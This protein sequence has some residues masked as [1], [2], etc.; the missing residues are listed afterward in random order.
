MHDE[1]LPLVLGL[2]PPLTASSPI[3]TSLSPSV[4]SLLSP[5]IPINN[6]LF[7]LSN[8]I[9]PTY[10]NSHCIFLKAISFVI[11]SKTLPFY[12]ASISAASTS[13]QGAGIGAFIALACNIYNDDILPIMKLV[14]ALAEQ[15]SVDHDAHVVNTIASLTTALGA[16]NSRVSLDSLSSEVVDPN[17]GGL[18]TILCTVCTVLQNQLHTFLT[19]QVI[20]D[21]FN[22]FFITQDA[23]R[24]T[25]NGS[26]TNGSDAASS[27]PNPYHLDWSK[28][29]DLIGGYAADVY[30]LGVHLQILHTCK[31]AED[32]LPYDLPPPPPNPSSTTSNPLLPYL[33]TALPHLKTLASERL[34]SQLL[35][36][37]INASLNDL[38]ETYFLTPHLDTLTNLDL[39]ASLAAYP[40]L[41]HVP[42]DFEYPSNFDSTATAPPNPPARLDRDEINLPL[43]LID[44]NPDSV[45]YSIYGKSKTPTPTLVTVRTQ[46][47]LVCDERLKISLDIELTKGAAVNLTIGNVT[48]IFEHGDTGVITVTTLPSSATTDLPVSTTRFKA[49]LNFTP[50]LNTLLLTP[51]AEHPP[52]ELLLPALDAGTPTPLTLA[53]D[54]VKLEGGVV[55]DQMDPKAVLNDLAVSYR[56]RGRGAMCEH[57]EDHFVNPPLNPLFSPGLAKGDQVHAL[58]PQ[59]PGLQ[60]ARRHLHPQL[61]RPLL[62]RVLQNCFPASRQRGRH[63]IYHHAEFGRVRQNSDAAE[64]DSGGGRAGEGDLE[65]EGQDAQREL[66]GTLEGSVMIDRI[67]IVRYH[68]DQRNTSG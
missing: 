3:F 7:S 20:V 6:V 66:S 40:A 54:V 21:P 47:P 32:M 64:E 28:V 2:H 26:T 27:N 56:W 41:R 51:P 49:T 53:G 19:T 8:T 10:A 4:L 31:T 46:Q 65:A 11:S 29:P 35:V 55:Q 57:D 1:V 36:E 52:V 39:P 23:S 43:N 12:R 17:S 5:L 60:R 15:N 30:S 44:A 22:Q 62:P 42:Y 61:H 13:N 18:Q 38:T 16:A 14:E 63:A 37:N 34:H 68:G 58:A 67:G 25:T 48:V 24:S 33:E 50:T 9:T 45:P 59:L